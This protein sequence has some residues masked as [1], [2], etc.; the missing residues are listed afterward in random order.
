MPKGNI[1]KKLGERAQKALDESVEAARTGQQKESV[2]RARLEFHSVDSEAGSYIGRPPARAREVA[3][4][5]PLPTGDEGQRG[6]SSFFRTGRV[7][8]GQS[9]E[10]Q[11]GS[12]D[13]LTSLPSCEAGGS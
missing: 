2:L 10:G 13:Q 1:H 4:V 3:P 8:G 7:K 11:V 5:G 6:G 9:E 12:P